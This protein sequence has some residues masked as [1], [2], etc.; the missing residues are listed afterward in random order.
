[1]LKGNSFT[2]LLKIYFVGSQAKKRQC[3]VGG[4]NNNNFDDENGSY[5]LVLHDHIA[6]RYEIL[7]IIGKGSFGQVNLKEILKK[8]NFFKK[9]I[10]AFDHKYQ[11]VII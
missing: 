8:N 1:M 11:Q 9:V 10:K 3:V 7:K 5:V 6:Y 2:S 4:S